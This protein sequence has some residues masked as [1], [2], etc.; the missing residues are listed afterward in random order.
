MMGG[1]GAFTA[2]SSPKLSETHGSWNERAALNMTNRSNPSNMQTRPLPETPKTEV[3]TELTR[4]DGQPSRSNTPGSVFDNIQRPA[5]VTLERI[6]GKANAN[7]DRMRQLQQRY[8]EQRGELMQSPSPQSMNMFGNQVI[9]L[10]WI[11]LVVL[12]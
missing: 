7:F 8:R 1:S 4:S 12:D 2:P 5:S 10:E 6:R 11:P 9:L 3:D